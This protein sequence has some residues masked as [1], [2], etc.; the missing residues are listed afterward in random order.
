MQIS[1]GMNSKGVGFTILANSSIIPYLRLQYPDTLVACLVV[2][3]VQKQRAAA[4]SDRVYAVRYQSHSCC[5]SPYWIICTILDLNFDRTWNRQDFENSCRSDQMSAFTLFLTQLRCARFF[6]ASTA[7]VV[8]S[9]DRY[10]PS[11]CLATRHHFWLRLLSV[12]SMHY[13]RQFVVPT[14]ENC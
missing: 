9:W 5:A 2:A 3:T 8:G 13:A 1:V 12:T 10:D 14:V 4:G 11:W 7:I 6:A